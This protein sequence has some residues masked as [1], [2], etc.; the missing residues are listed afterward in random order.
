LPVSEK[1]RLRSSYSLTLRPRSRISSAFD[2][3]QSNI[4]AVSA[5]DAIYLGATDGD[6]DRDL[7]VTADTEGTDGVTGLA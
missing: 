5:V 6:V 4:T 3:R 7:L 1:L 2:V